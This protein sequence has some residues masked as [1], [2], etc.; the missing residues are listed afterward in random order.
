[1]TQWPD[2]R[3][4][5]YRSFVAKYI[6]HTALE[7]SLKLEMLLMSVLVQCRCQTTSTK[8]FSSLLMA[9]VHCAEATQIQQFI[10]DKCKATSATQK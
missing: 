7:M 8:P 10:M 3:N 4:I 9:L 2:F 6:L 1:M 5:F